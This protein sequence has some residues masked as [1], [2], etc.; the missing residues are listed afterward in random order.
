VH[1]E[2]AMS[3]FRIGDK[4]ISLDRIN[5]AIDKILKL[6]SRGCSQQEAADAAGVDRTFV[7]RLENLGEIRK[8]KRIGVL[9]FPI[10]NKEEI[11]QIFR[12][13]GIDNCLLMNE[14][15]RKRFVLDRSG[16]DLVNELMILI[17]E[18]RQY[19]TVIVLASDMRNRLIEALLDQQVI[20]LD[21]GSSPLTSD[22]RVDP[23]KIQNILKYIL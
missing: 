11:A 19:D 6:R 8:G 14:E 1:K 3:F 15:E 4:T 16:P 18:Y 21:I 10:E 23:D 17:K 5:A 20:M 22:V 2:A 13:H 12:D 9:G 7:S